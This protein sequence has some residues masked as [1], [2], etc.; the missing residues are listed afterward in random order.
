[1][2]SASQTKL[3]AFGMISTYSAS[4]VLLSEPDMYPTWAWNSSTLY[5][6]SSS[7]IANQRQLNEVTTDINAVDL[8][9]CDF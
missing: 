2:P 4:F 9:A 8:L 3:N 5:S 6:V 7:T 1:M